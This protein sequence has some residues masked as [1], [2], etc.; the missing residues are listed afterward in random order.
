MCDL[1]DDCG[2]GSDEPSSCNRPTCRPNEFTCNNQRCVLMEW[3]CDGDND[4]GDMSDER[5]C[6]KLNAIISIFSRCKENGF[7]SLPFARV[8]AI[9]H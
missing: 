5:N 6:C 4:C 7:F 3:K 2:D 8:E 9:V 1:D